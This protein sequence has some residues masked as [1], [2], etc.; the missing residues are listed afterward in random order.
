LSATLVVVLV[1]ACQ[2]GIPKEALE[3]SAQSLQQRQLE[4]RRF[5]TIDEAKLL[6]ASA[7]V[8][9]DLGFTLDESETPVG[10]IV[11]SKDRD[12]TEAGQV[13]GAVIMAVLLG[14]PVAI[15]KDQKIRASLVTKPGEDRK[16]TNV[17]ITFQR[18]V[19]NSQGQVSKIEGL[20][21]PVL[22]QQFF[23][24]L[25]QSVFLQANQI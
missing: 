14:V 20:D 16:S 2:P 13:V 1:A 7:A 25:A 22:Y 12:A 5:D 17:R 21:D 18:T 3:L 11:A 8:L 19:W 23:D 10:L 9:Q 6:S 24:Q 15:D 4:T